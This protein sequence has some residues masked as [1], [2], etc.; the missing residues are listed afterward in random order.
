MNQNRKRYAQKTG[1]APGTLV[2][3]G[4]YT[5]QKTGLTRIDYHAGDVVDHRRAR[6]QRGAHDGRLV[7][8]DRHRHAPGRGEYMDSC[9]RAIRHSTD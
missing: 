3:T 4:G 7:G 5:E 1:M 8:I 6:L 2:Y 9:H